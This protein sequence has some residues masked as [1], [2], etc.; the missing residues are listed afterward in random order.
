MLV[1]PENLF[2]SLKKKTEQAKIN[3]VERREQH[4]QLSR[5]PP[6][7]DVSSVLLHFQEIFHYNYTKLQLPRHTSL[8]FPCITL[9]T[10][11]IKVYK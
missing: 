8:R 9:R 11:T 7:S 6:Q 4:K 1:F 5:F 3:K 2:L 10:S